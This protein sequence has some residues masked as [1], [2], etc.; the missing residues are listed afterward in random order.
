MIDW[1]KITTVFLDLDGTLLDLHFDNH[2][3]LEYVP[4]CYAQK[5]SLDI[6]KSHETLRQKYSAAY[7]SLNWY[8]VDYWTKELQL[9]IASLKHSIREKICVRPYVEEFLQALHMR[10]KRVV[11]VTNA[12]PLSF[13]IKLQETGIGHY[14]HRIITSH[15]LAHAK[16]EAEFW[17]KLEEVE[18]VDKAATLFIDD[19]FSVLDAA[20]DYGIEHLLA[21]KCPDSTEEEK[22]HPHYHL[23]G[24]FRE[25]APL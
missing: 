15:S 17:L 6:E 23:L 16:E 18:P 22:E 4:Q 14:F 13:E 19:N 10:G 11:L 20:R 8:C 7:G 9:D 12:H 5:H 2:F 21:I 24:S 3:W 25:V 1:T